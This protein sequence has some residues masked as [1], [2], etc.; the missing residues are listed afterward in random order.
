[1]VEQVTLAKARDRREEPVA[2]G[3][4][5]LGF[6]A[7]PRPGVGAG[8]RTRDGPAVTFTASRCASSARERAFVMQW[9]AF[10]LRM[11]V[12]TKSRPALRCMNSTE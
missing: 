8:P 3:E 2:P 1:M 12:T 10:Q 11:S 6:T 4:R 7:Q 9:F 5:L